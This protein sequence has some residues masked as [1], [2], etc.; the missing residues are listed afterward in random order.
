MGAGVALNSASTVS[1]APGDTWDLNG[2]TQIVAGLGGVAIGSS[3]GSDGTGYGS[4]TLGSGGS[5]T[6]NVTGGCTFGGVISGAGSL[7]KP[8]PARSPSP[9]R[10]P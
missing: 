6:V 8:V 3:D 4:I 10:I 2:T 1:V 9:A 7:T 5:L